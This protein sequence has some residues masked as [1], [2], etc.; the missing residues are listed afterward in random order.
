MQ[1]SMQAEQT[2][3][4]GVLGR[5]K[6]LPDQGAVAESTRD[7]TKRQSCQGSRQIRIRLPEVRAAALLKLT[8]STRAHLIG[9]LQ[10]EGVDF[11]KAAALVTELRELRLAI[12]NGLRQ[13][14]FRGAA[15]DAGLL[16]GAIKRINELLGG[17][18]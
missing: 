14:Q 18:K 11:T 12:I 17:G 10:N 13:A 1:P 15:V 4:R 8:P 2:S 7:E 6:S 3:T 5:E 9:L 16:E